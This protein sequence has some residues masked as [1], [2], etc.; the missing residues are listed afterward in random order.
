[1]KKIKV[2]IIYLIGL[3]VLSISIGLVFGAFIFNQVVNMDAEIGGIEI[4]SK[5]FLIYAKDHELESTNINYEKAEKLRKDTV[6]TIEGI[7]L[8]YTSN[9]ELTTDN[10]AIDGKTYYQYDGVKFDIVN[11][12]VGASTQG[13]FEEVNYNKRWFIYFSNSK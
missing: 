13:Y 5:N 9:Y 2:N 11:V 3:L 4:K 8:S 12:N 10:V 1:M 6:A 7:K